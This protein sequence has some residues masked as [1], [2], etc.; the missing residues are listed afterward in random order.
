M[1]HALAVGCVIGFI[2]VPTLLRGNGGT[3]EE[4]KPDRKID[5][6]TGDKRVDFLR[7]GQ[8]VATYHTDPALFKPHF[9]PILTPSGKPINRRFPMENVPGETKDHIHHRGVWFCHGD[10]IPEG[11]TLKH[12]IRGVTG[13]DFWAE[14]PGHGRI[15]AE[16]GPLNFM[17]GISNAAGI[18][19]FHQW[20]TFDGVEVLD[21]H[22]TIW[23]IDR[24][25]A[26]VFVFDIELLAKH[27]PITF[28]DTKEGCL[29]VRVAD[30]MNEKNG[31]VL[32]NAQ[33]RRGEKNCW[34]RLSAW[35]DYSGKIDGQT[36][37][38]TIMA[39]PSN[40]WHTAWHARGYGLMAAN[41]FGRHQSG[42]PAR[43]GQTEL[44]R[45][46]KGEKLKL[47]YGVL[48]HPG[49]VRTGKVAEHY[50]WFTRWPGTP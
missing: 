42:F 43:L 47:R 11:L 16:V 31:G 44:V 37:G 30:S 36:V 38:I 49:D 6:R 22:R 19:T 10:V 20:E 15:S 33:G 14:G 26:Y 21:E 2:L 50:E 7:N 45:L 28:G 34:G 27:H 18:Q 9:H 12:K 25:E 46:A 17:E 4:P 8:V 3:R 5:I 13:V 41:P 24:G 35:C 39:H 40:D 32:E 48:I 29:G 23:I 1:R